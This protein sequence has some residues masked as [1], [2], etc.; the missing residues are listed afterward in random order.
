MGW[1]FEY[2][3]LRLAEDALTAAEQ[4]SIVTLANQSYPHAEL[5]VHPQHCQVCRNAIVVTAAMTAGL[6]M[7]TAIGLLSQLTAEE[8]VTAFMVRRP[9]AA[10]ASEESFEQRSER[11]AGPSGP[12]VPDQARDADEDLD[13]AGV[14]AV[15]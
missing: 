13:G 8:S 12:A 1:K 3:G 11:V 7:P 14:A 10:Q 15:V 2:A 9:S 6:P 4:A 5:D